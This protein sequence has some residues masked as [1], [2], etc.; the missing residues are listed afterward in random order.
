MRLGS[1][2][3]GE[4]ASKRWKG[5]RDCYASSNKRRLTGSEDGEASPYIYFEE[6]SFLRTALADRSGYKFVIKC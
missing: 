5:I 6:L 2:L 3:D 1:F 4:R